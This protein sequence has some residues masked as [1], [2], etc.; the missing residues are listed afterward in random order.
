M[1]SMRPLSTATVHRRLQQMLGGSVTRAQCDEIALRSCGNSA[2][3]FAL[4]TDLVSQTP[5]GLS[6]GDT[7]P[8]LGQVL[9]REQETVGAAYPPEERAAMSLLATTREMVDRSVLRSLADISWSSALARWLDLGLVRSEAGD[10][11]W[12]RPDMADAIVST[13]TERR[14]R[15][16]HRA[17]A[18]YWA[19]FSPEPGSD[20]HENLVYHS[21]QSDAYRR[22]VHAG[23]DSA[24]YW[25][26]KHQA[27]RALN[28]LDNVAACLAQVDHPAPSL[29]FEQ[30]IAQA[31]ARRV[32]ARYAEAV[33]DLQAAL[34]HP[35]VSGQLRWEAE[36]YKRIGDLCKSLKQPEEGKKALEEALARFRQ[37][38][39]KVEISHVL[40]NI[41]NILFVAG[42]LDL[43]QSTYE[44]AL[45]LQRELKLQREIASTLNNIG[46]LLVLRSQYDRATRH[47]T[48]AVAI[49]RVLDDPEELARSLNNLAV[50]YVETGKYQR[51]SDVLA[52]SYEINVQA[53]KTG[54]QLF[55]LENMAAVAMARGEWARAMEHCET[56]LRLCDAAE[57]PE[58]RLPYLLVMSGVALAQGNYNLV[59]QTLNEADRILAHVEDPDLELQRLTF[60]AEWSHWRNQ[61][62]ETVA[63]AG[64]VVERAKEEKLPTWTT[65]GYLLRARGSMLSNPDDPKL[66]RWLEKSLDIALETG[67]LPEQIRSRVLMAERLIEQHELETAAEHLRKCETL[68]L[69]SAAKPLFLP[70]SHALGC[71]Y[72]RRGDRE[73]AL[74][75]FETTRKLA[76]NLTSPE[77]TWRFLARC[78][79]LLVELR[80][81][82]EAVEQYR[83][84]LEILEHLVSQLQP[85]DRGT[86]M[87]GRE[88]VALEG[89]LRT[90]HEA[91][92]RT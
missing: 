51:A 33:E 15:V 1:L 77:W 40:N 71:F 56:G 92:V 4:A 79:H 76:T 57:A 55:N 8:A 46:G 61:A 42:E 37:L 3:L 28:V 26:A 34:K 65:R 88:K 67:A 66:Q 78:G 18:E 16:V 2:R 54:E 19:S 68:L 50:A 29:V 70:F 53:G 85:A 23:L 9:A 72:E 41:G 32:L 6:P 91:L 69:E 59:P 20:A 73:M 31:E 13:L 30:A 21:L 25:T 86:Y 87:Q 12:D 58:N 75:I 47:L 5:T 63:L 11:G 7:G 36:I 22:A 10:F 48:E 27:T 35:A 80:R 24:R 89:G 83:G 62:D 49:K 81:Y 14:R 17:W 38:E 43:A 82:D 60:A 64:R 84:G 45:A 74:S 39:D 44:E 90:C 52:E